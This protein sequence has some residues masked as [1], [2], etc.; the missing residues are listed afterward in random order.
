MYASLGPSFQKMPTNLKKNLKPC[1]RANFVFYN[2]RILGD[3]FTSKFNLGPVAVR[4]LFCC[5]LF[6]VV[7]PIVCRGLLLG[8][9]F[10][11]STL[12]PFSYEK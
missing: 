3:D 7:A 2:S 6:I 8:L 1:M 12:C 9:C 5:C 11:C 10:V 4:R